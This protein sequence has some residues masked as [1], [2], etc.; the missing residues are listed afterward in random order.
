MTGIEPAFSA[1]DAA[2]VAIKF[3][4]PWSDTH[5][6]DVPFTGSDTECDCE[7]C[8]TAAAALQLRQRERL[9]GDEIQWQRVEELFVDHV[10]AVD[11][12]AEYAEALAQWQA[13]SD[14]FETAFDKFIARRAA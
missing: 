11:T 7:P 4:R 9:A 10:A 13:V 3:S 8:M 5:S 12:Q 2:D 14:K 6:G 1:W